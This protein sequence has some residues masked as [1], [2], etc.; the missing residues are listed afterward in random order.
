MLPPARGK[1]AM[2][3]RA[4][5][6]ARVSG[7]DRK[8]AT[9][10][11]EGQL[12]LCRSYAQEK[13]YTVIGEYFEDKEK[14]TSGAD[15][16]PELEKVLRLAFQKAYDVLIVREIDRLARNRFKQLAIENELDAQGITVEYALGRYD[17]TDEGR[18]LRGLVGEFAE[19]ERSKIK[20]RT[21]RGR[22]RAVEQGHILAR[23]AVYGYDKKE[24][25]GIRTLVIN[26]DEAAVVRM[27]FQLYAYQ[28][29]SLHKIIDYLEERN[30]AKPEKRPKLKGKGL[31]R[32]SNG[33]LAAILKNEVYVG[34][35]YY[36]KT[37]YTKVDGR[38]KSIPRDRSEWWLVEVP[39]IIDQATFERAQSIRR[40][41]KAV[42]G[43]QRKN[44][45]LLGE[46]RM[47]CGHCGRNFSGM[48]KYH[49]DKGF[50]YYKC[51]AHHIPKRYEFRC[52]NAQFK[53]EP[54]DRVVW[55]WVKSLLLDPAVLRAAYT[56][57]TKKQQEAHKPLLSMIA[58]SEAKL[59]QARER[60]QRLIDAYAAG[61]LGLDEIAAQKTEIDKEI[62]ELQTAV[63]KLR[64]DLDPRVLQPVKLETL[65]AYAADMRKGANLSDADPQA[66][67]EVLDLV[68]TEVT[69]FYSPERGR[70]VEVK[71]ILGAGRFFADVAQGSGGNG[72][73]GATVSSTTRCSDNGCIANGHIAT[74]FNT[75]LCIGR[76]SAR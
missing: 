5:L 47:K 69:A 17:D 68:R 58:T 43:K 64:A 70:E 57:Y 3:K 12:E 35:W 26:E 54:T 18:L 27:I 67:Q 31:K 34:R 46:G 40:R 13:G 1:Q 65:E 4:I 33:T 21:A 29:Y 22:Q 16:L 32:W 71:C 62:N 25:N 19:F 14:H 59:E 7:D 52:D 11:V 39:P 76:K 60:K 30:I 8:A 15:W 48:T 75:N 2:S 28:R 23:V 50:G 73:G 61:V 41:N 55:E 74:A 56:V 38:M 20:A 9:S 63:Q 6:Y 49:K 51:N 10:S 24:V 53:M 66:Q 72:G 44:F 36:N 42:K 37:I 45:Y